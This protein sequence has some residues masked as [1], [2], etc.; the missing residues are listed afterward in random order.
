MSER[1]SHAGYATLAGLAVAAVI[2]AASCRITNLPSALAPASPPH[3]VA[4]PAPLLETV[5]LPA[6]AASRVGRTP[7][8]G[9]HGESAFFLIPEAGKPSE[10]LPVVEDPNED[11]VPNDR[12]LAL[13][14]FHVLLLDLGVGRAEFADGIPGG[15]LLGR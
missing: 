12:R 14:G 10:Q 11:G 4:L 13:T 5:V 2:G 3:A 8:G 15:G 9:I 6:A 1:L 7:A